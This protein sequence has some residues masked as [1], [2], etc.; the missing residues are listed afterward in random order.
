MVFILG[1][2]KADDDSF[3]RIRKDPSELTAKTSSKRK[4]EELASSS[5]SASSDDEHGGMHLSKIIRL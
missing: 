4:K 3:Y 5:L 1:L 2:D